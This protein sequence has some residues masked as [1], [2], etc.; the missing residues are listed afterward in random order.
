MTEYHIP[1]SE[2][3]DLAVCFE[4]IRRRGKSAKLAT[5]SVSYSTLAD[6]KWKEV[7]RFDNT[8]DFPH[9]HIFHLLRQERKILLG[10]Q[11]DSAII[12]QSVLEDVKKNFT[13]FK[14]HF[15]QT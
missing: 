7:I 8:H 4:T 2:E 15:L 1:L 6:G 13:K 12:F 11:K 10:D 3:D 5:F 9:Q 14:Q